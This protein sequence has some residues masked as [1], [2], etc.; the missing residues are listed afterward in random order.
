MSGRLHASGKYKID[1]DVLFLNIISEMEQLVLVKYTDQCM[2]RGK[3]IVRFDEDNYKVNYISLAQL[4]VNDSNAFISEF[5]FISLIT[6]IAQGLIAP[7]FMNGRH[8]SMTSHSRRLTVVC[9]TL[10][11]SGNMIS[12]PGAS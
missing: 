8:G 12:R 5:R 11:M 7:I 1:H 3:I 9:N 4:I 2:Y 10:K 6:A